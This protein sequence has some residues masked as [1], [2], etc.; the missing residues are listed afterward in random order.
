MACIEPEG[1]SFQ[2][3]RHSFADYERKQSGNLYTV[4]K[5]LGHISMQVTLHYLKSF[6]RMLSIS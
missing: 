5:A 4:S 1:L 3:A 2:V 6:N